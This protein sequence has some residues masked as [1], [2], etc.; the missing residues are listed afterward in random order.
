MVDDD[1]ALNAIKIYCQY[2]NGGHA[3]EITSSVMHFG[4]WTG[5]E[6]CSNN[7]FINGYN[8]KV[9]AKF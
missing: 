8:L 3:G 7:G 1:T 4:S 5:A 2:P 9:G 6:L